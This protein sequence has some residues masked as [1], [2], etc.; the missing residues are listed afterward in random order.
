M[1]TTFHAQLNRFIGETVRIYVDGG[2]DTGMVGCLMGVGREYIEV[3]SLNSRHDKQIPNAVSMIPIARISAITYHQM[4][5]D[6]NSALATQENDIA[7]LFLLIFIY[8]FIQSR[9]LSKK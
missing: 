4:G 1:F 7:L 8:F 5:L 3:I 2:T 6:E 9:K